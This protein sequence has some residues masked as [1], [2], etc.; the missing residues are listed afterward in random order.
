MDDRLE[1]AS[2]APRTIVLGAPDM[3]KSSFIRAVLQRSGKALLD[4]TPGTRW[5]DHREA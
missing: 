3:G 1:A 4:S 2:V 5:V